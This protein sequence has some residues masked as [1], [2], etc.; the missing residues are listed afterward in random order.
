MRNKILSLCGAGVIFTVAGIASA[1]VVD[2]VTV[3]FEDDFDSEPSSGLNYNSFQNWDVAAGYVDLLGEAPEDRGYYWLEGY[4]KFVDLDGTKRPENADGYRAGN[5]VTKQAFDL[6]PGVL[7]R[8]EFDLAGNQSGYWPTF[9]DD[10]VVVSVG[11]AFSE[12]FTRDP[13][14]GFLTF[15]REF[16][17]SEFMT[18]KISFDHAGGDNA[19]LYLD[20]VRFSQIGALATVP[21]PSAALAGLALLSALGLTRRRRTA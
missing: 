15:T 8:L 9:E 10:E 21:A 2:P 18:G 6:H 12:L 3:L 7:Y 16:S 17:V 5:L 11:D 14:T 1:G 13:G 4:G 19:G 20:N